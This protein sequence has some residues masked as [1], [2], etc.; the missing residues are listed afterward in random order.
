ME[1]LSDLIADALEWQKKVKRN[2]TK[3]RKGLE[4]IRKSKTTWPCLLPKEDM[5]EEDL[6]LW[7][8]YLRGNKCSFHHLFGMT[9]DQREL[10]LEVLIYKVM[11]QLPPGQ[12]IDKHTANWIYG[13][14]A[15]IEFPLHLYLC[16]ILRDLCKSADEVRS[17]LDDLPENEIVEA[18]TPLNIISIL[19]TQYFDQS[20]V[21]PLGYSFPG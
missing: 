8:R 5:A 12:S 17:H 10:A 20:N 15:C 6:E 14:L 3:M 16:V 7:L 11:D 9:D 21:V 2:F 19:V 4:K 1:L 13:I 18:G